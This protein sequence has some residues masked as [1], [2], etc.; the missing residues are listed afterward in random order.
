MAY[1]AD[2]HHIIFSVPVWLIDLMEG[3]RQVDGGL[4]HPCTATAA[5]SISGAI[6][7]PAYRSCSTHSTSQINELQKPDHTHAPNNRCDVCV[8]FD[9]RHVGLHLSL[10]PRTFT[11]TR[12]AIVNMSRN[13]GNNASVRHFDCPSTY[14][15]Q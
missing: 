11:L 1:L 3:L 12:K 2:G 10:Q 9:S 4:L 15:T 8:T 5:L 7:V 6:S 14:V 13:K